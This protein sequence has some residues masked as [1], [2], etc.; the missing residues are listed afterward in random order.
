MI[1]DRG[2]V[3]G[4]KTAGPARWN[5][6][7]AKTGLEWGTHHLLPVQRGICYGR[8]EICQKFRLSPVLQPVVRP[9]AVY[10]LVGFDGQNAAQDTALLGG[11]L[12]RELGRV[13][14]GRALF[15]RV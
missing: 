13:H 9:W 7:Q 14:H 10:R 8:G 11:E 4:E 1:M 2:S 15:G 12:R 5:P 3:A 6:T